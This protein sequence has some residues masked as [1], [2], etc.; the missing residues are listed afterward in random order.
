M[1]NREHLPSARTVIVTTGFG[2]IKLSLSDENLLH[3][4]SG[5]SHF[6]NTFVLDGRLLSVRGTLERLPSGEWIVARTE[7]GNES[8]AA[9]SVTS[10]PRATYQSLTVPKKERDSIRSMLLDAVNRYFADHPEDLVSAH[11]ARVNNEICHAERQIIDLQKKVKDW[12]AKRLELLA[13]EE[14]IK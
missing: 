12:E 14:T 6:D 8:A 1:S 4:Y 9:L 3:F 13:E 2:D 11:R 5:N 10:H 7:G